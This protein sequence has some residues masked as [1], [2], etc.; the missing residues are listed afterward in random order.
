MIRKYLPTD[1]ETIIKVWYESTTLAHPFM[2]EKFKEKEAEAIRNIYL[3]NTETWVY[4]KDQQLI[5]FISMIKN[6]V[7]A[8]FLLP[9]FHGEGIGKQLMDTVAELFDELEVEVFEKNKIGRKFYDRYGFTF[10]K[11]HLH[12]ETGEELLRLKFVK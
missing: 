5:G 10:L 6:E 7:G 8:I 9:A 2:T 1:M 11:K 12:E 3:P 4:E